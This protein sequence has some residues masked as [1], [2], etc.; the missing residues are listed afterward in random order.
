MPLALKSNLY[1]VVVLAKIVINPGV[2]RSV[3]APDLH[4]LQYL[5]TSAVNVLHLLNTAFFP[6]TAAACGFASQQILRFDRFMH[7][8]RHAKTNPGRFT[9]FIR[10][11]L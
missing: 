11:G 6:L 1:A 9:I 8:T 5:D 10:A 3:I 2:S 7:P 4:T